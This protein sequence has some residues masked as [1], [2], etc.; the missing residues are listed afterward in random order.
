MKGEILS[1]SNEGDPRK[2]HRCGKSCSC[3]S[4]RRS[5]TGGLTSGKLLLVQLWGRKWRPVSRA[6]LGLVIIYERVG[7]KAG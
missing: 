3:L 1:L 5:D 7:E 6:S 2:G 4:L